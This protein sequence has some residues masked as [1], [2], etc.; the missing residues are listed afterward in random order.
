MHPPRLRYCG[1]EPNV[2]I[3]V[4]ARAL[5]AVDLVFQG[6]YLFRENETSLSLVD[7]RLSGFISIS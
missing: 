5:A 1:Q 6:M 3:H 7:K 2:A 4:H